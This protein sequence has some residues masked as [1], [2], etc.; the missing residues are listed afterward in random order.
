MFILPLFSV[1]NRVTD[2]GHSHLREYYGKRY[3]ALENE[4]S[5]N[6]S[7]SFYPCSQLIQNL[8]WSFSHVLASCSL[9]F[10]Y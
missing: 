6:Q 4:W 5:V 2:H 7:L 9:L 3:N 10:G 8:I 1:T